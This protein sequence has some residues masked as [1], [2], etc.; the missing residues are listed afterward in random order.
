MEE[1]LEEAM[2]LFKARKLNDK[3]FFFNKINSIR[4]SIITQIELKYLPGD[5]YWII[6]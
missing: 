4:S 5:C 2:G 6:N 1:T 3:S